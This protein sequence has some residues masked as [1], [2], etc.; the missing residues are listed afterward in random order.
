MGLAEQ[1]KLLQQAQGDPARLALAT[2]DLAFP[3]LPD[4]DRATLRSALEAAAVPHWCDATILASLTG[5]PESTAA[6]QWTRLRSLPVVE[7]F[8]A[9]GEVA[10][11]VHEASRL[12][13]RQRLAETDAARLRD[14]SARALQVFKG[15]PEPAGRIEWIYHL[16]LA[17]REAAADE[18]ERLDRVWSGTARTEDLAA[19]SAALTELDRAGLLSGRTRVRARLIVAQRDAEVT[20]AASL[21]DTA[22]ELLRAAKTCDDARLIG[23]VH[24]LVGDVAAARGDLPAAEHAFTEYLV[25]SERLAALAPTNIGWL[26]DLAVAHSRLGDLALARGDLPATERAFSQSLAIAERLAALDPTNT[27]WQRDLA[28]AHNRIGD[29]AQTRGDLPAAEHAFTQTLAIAEQLAALDPTNTYWQRDL[30]IA[31]SRIGDLAQARGDRAA[32]QHAF[33]QTLAILERLAAL[34][35]TNINWHHDLA[36][37]RSRV[38]GLAQPRSSAPEQLPPEGALIARLTRM[39]AQ[40]PDDG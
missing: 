14:L 37:A 7:P 4:G 6:E 24:C 26:R 15:N 17:D 20:G 16:L 31:H 33:T 35:P 22:N 38:G 9:R 25:A 36:A 29:L 8:P 5:V 23:D 3:D 28:I 10:G 39:S 30:A 40:R 27:L 32:A 1:L 11:N 18:L 2:V 34:D 13:L 19:L 21:G 12:A